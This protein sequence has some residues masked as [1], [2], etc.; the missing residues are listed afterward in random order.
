MGK[1][2]GT[3]NASEILRRRYLVGRPARQAAVAWE[4][5]N[6]DWGEYWD[7]GCAVR[8]GLQALG[9][10]RRVTGVA[11]V[12][13]AGLLILGIAKAAWLWV[14]VLVIAALLAIIGKVAD[15]PL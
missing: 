10:P 7:E 11:V 5:A 3:T 9:M 12:A 6:M 2:A 15:T 1:R 14:S 8:L 13:L 4:K